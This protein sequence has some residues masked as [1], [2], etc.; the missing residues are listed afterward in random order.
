MKAPS[1]KAIAMAILNNDLNFHSIGFSRE[2]SS[3]SIYLMSEIKK[4]NQINLLILR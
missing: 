3:L 4:T 1:Y 2:E